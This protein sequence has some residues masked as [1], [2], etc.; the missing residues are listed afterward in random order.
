MR[1]RGYNAEFLNIGVSLDVFTPD[2]KPRSGTPPIVFMGNNYPGDLFP[3]SKERE[4]MVRFLQKRYGAR[5]AVYGRNWGKGSEWIDEPSEAAA[6]RSCRIAINHNHFND[7]SR[8]S[9]DRILR[10][11]ASGAFA[12]SNHWPQIE[13]DYT[14][15]EHLRTWRSFDELGRTIDY[16]LDHEEERKGIAD[17][18]CRHVHANHNWAVRMKELLRFFG[19]YRKAAA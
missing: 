17:A 3:L 4:D 16:Y 18:G 12:L 8:F 6:Y 11:M 5:F 13:A 1:A 15:G 14:D 7:V 19:T 9:S 10:I 2:G